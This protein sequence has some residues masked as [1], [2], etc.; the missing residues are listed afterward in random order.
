MITAHEHQNGYCDVLQAIQ[1]IMFMGTPHRGANV[2]YW[3][4]TSGKVL[5]VL[6]LKIPLLG[7]AK[8]KALEDLQSRTLEKIR[9]EF[10]EP[11]KDIKIFTYFE[12]VKTPGLNDLASLAFDTL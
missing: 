12:R 3:G 7:S 5:E 10:V 1:G 11:G 9:S 4:I 8:I 2:A 6:L